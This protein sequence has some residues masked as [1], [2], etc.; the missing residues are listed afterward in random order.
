MLFSSKVFIFLFLPIVLLGYYILFHHS[1]KAQNM[2]LLIMSL[3]FYAYGEPKTILLMIISIFLNW[4]F[5]LV[6]D[7]YR[8][9]KKVS[10]A[11][12]ILAI[13]FNIGLLFV[14]KY[15]GF[16]IE[17]INQ[18]FHVNISIP[19][20]L[21]P[22]GISFFTFQGLSY[23][24]DVYR[25]NGK[26]QKSVFNVGLYI[27]FFPQLIAG[28]IV[29][30][31]T[32]SKQINE[33]KESMLKIYI[34]IKRFIIGLSKKVILSNTFALIADSIFNVGTNVVLTSWIGAFAYTLQI[35]YDF[36]GYSDMAIGLGKLFGFDFLENFN[37][38]YI[39]TS[40]SEFWRRWHIS[41]GAWF[42]DYVYFPLGGSKIKSK[43]RLVFNLFVVWF[44]T[45][46]WH[47]ANITFIVW[48][49]LYF[50]LITAEKIFGLKKIEKKKWYPLFGFIYTMFFV[51]IGWVIFRSNNLNDACHY[52]Q[53]MF[54]LKNV[55]LW[56]N[57]SLFYIQN[58]LIIWILG[59]VF[60]TPIMKKFLQKING[61]KSL[62]IVY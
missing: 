45:G 10:K 7:K 47:G 30:Y 60:S 27:S 4:I 22:I 2:F 1:R 49:L 59:I 56:N 5:G 25:H 19:Q 53:T 35:Y 43:L 62:L 9:D 42:R 51:I 31:D 52:L 36:S 40:I 6:I 58:Y 41:L 8:L 28:P 16:S 55:I 32:V 12:L 20:I 13:L 3:L 17:M 18:L 39:S 61:A 38:P 54:G 23:V 21:L 50:V 34:G 57:H 37:Y 11:V 15:F 44:L 33:R 26:V 14:Y 29:R 24:I 46:L 48:G